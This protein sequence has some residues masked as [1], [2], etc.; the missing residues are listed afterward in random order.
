MSPQRPIPDD[1]KANDPIL[2]VLVG[3]ASIALVRRRFVGKSAASALLLAPLVIP[4]IVFGISLLLFF[5][6]AAIA[7]AVVVM[8]VSLVVVVGAE[9]ARRIAERRLGTIPTS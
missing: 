5:H 7:V 6:A 8:V 2:Y 9:I 3:L 4:Y 1:E